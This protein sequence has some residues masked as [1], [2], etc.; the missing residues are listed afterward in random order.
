M[1]EAS[2]EFVCVRIES[3]ES[4]A[5]KKIVRSHLNGRF[6]NTAFCVLAPDGETRLT[7]S[8]RGPRQVFRNDLVAGLKEIAAM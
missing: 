3:Y 7:R 6:E 1:I 8:G 5:T 4:E 2:R